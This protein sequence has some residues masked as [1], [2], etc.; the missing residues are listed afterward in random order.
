MAGAAVV[1]LLVGGALAVRHL[2]SDQG[3]G[4]PAAD[5]LHRGATGPVTTSP[6]G[7]PRA[8]INEEKYRP[9]ALGMS[10]AS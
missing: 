6:G 4:N 8:A 9:D 10:S 3:H 2:A 1:C 5:K 7:P